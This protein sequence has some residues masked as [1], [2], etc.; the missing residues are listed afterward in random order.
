ME[1]IDVEESRINT[2]G[3]NGISM[4]MLNIYLFSYD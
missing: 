4:K 2:T 1:I 3:E